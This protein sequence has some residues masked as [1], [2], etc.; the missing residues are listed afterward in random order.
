MVCIKCVTCYC[1]KGCLT[2][3]CRQAAIRWLFVV[4][5][6]LLSCCAIVMLLSLDCVVVM[7]LIGELS[8]LPCQHAASR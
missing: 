6:L 1:H 5:L 4:V 8:P 3:S 2:V 7:Q